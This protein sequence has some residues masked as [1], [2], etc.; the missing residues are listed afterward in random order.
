MTGD[1]V[2]HLHEGLFL[3]LLLGLGKE[4]AGDRQ[5][6]ED[7]SCYRHECFH[8]SLSSSS[9]WTT[10]SRLLTCVLRSPRWPTQLRAG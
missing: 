10:L 4:L 1:R 3:A 5:S 2:K 7:G 9:R 6:Q 8:R